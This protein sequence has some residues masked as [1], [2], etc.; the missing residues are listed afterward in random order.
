MIRLMIVTLLA[1]SVSLSPAEPLFKAAESR[2]ADAV[3]LFDGKDLSSWVKVQSSEP[4]PWK[5]E[6]DYMEVRGGSIRTKEEFGDVQLHVEFW[7][8]NMPDAQGQARA[9]SGVYL[10]GRYEI[11]ILDSY[12]LESQSNDC[13]A[14]YGVAAPMMNACRPPEQW[15]AYDIIF[16]SS[17][18]D[19]EGK[20][21]SNPRMSV[22]HNGVWIHDSVEITSSTT[23][24]MN[25]GKT[26]RGPIMLQD[27]GNP[28][29][30]RNIWLREIGTKH[31][32]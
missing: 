1:I 22:L 19:G 13:G 27:H 25:D 14:I 20:Q 17:R 7:L 12:G 32:P 2:P 26:A 18:F 3:V 24:A 8:P 21:I 5:L 10:Q 23:A 16:H 11:Q 29:R 15:Q 28:V 9:N 31:T 30:F 4:A 6:G